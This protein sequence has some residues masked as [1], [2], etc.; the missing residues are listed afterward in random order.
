MSTY[1]QCHHLVTSFGSPII[2]NQSMNQSNNQLINQTSKGPV[3]SL[4]PCVCLCVCMR[5]SAKAFKPVF[6]EG[7]RPPEGLKPSEYHVYCPFLGLD[8]P[9]K[10]PCAPVPKISTVKVLFWPDSTRPKPGLG[11]SDADISQS[12]SVPQVSTVLGKRCITG[13]L[14]YHTFLSLNFV[15]AIYELFP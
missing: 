3:Q 15:V 5:F 10:T 13:K 1:I 11:P 8:T 2:L 4:I 7:W 9:A 14:C 12:A 6:T